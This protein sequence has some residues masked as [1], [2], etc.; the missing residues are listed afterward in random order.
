MSLV[1]ADEWWAEPGLEPRPHLG[2]A[3]WPGRLLTGAE[4]AG[5]EQP[6]PLPA[7]PPLQFYPLPTVARPPAL[8]S[9]VLL[10]GEIRLALAGQYATHW[11][12]ALGRGACALGGAGLNPAVW[13]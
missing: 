9:P 1:R 4:T 12:W 7:P 13:R 6:R 11:S 5:G 10:L 2:T 8:R 3:A